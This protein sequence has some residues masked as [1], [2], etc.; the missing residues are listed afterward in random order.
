MP[1]PVMPEEYER[2]WPGPLVSREEGADGPFQGVSEKKVGGGAGR[3]RWG[4]VVEG[5]SMKYA[6]DAGIVA[7]LKKKKRLLVDVL[8]QEVVGKL[9]EWGD[10]SVECITTR[11]DALEGRDFLK[12]EEGDPP[13][14]TYLP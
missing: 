5:Q 8:V 9:S 3:S 7:V 12:R 14:I 2:Q 13:A 1:P 11:I 4:G 10:V 6:V